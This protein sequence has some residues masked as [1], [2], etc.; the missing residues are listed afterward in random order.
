[1]SCSQFIRLHGHQGTAK[2]KR[3]TIPPIQSRR[4]LMKI[5][6]LDLKSQYNEYKES[7]LSAIMQVIDDQSF[8]LGP[9][10]ASFEQCLGNYLKLPPTIGVSSGTDAL[11]ISLMALNIGPGDEVV[12][13]ALS[14][15][16]TA[17]V[18]A[19]LGARPIFAD[20][21]PETFNLETD[22]LNAVLNHRTKVV[23]PVHL[24]GQIAR[25]DIRGVG[26]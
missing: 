6:F 17:G 19:R 8:V 26:C 2:I 1:M 21:N 24:F 3:L 18:V 10:V 5:P 7:A 23:I 16:A 25:L 4:S 15:F 14:F 20:I 22:E 13:P 9:H 12:I 11:L